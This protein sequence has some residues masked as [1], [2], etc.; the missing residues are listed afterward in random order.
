MDADH[1]DKGVTFAGRNTVLKNAAEAKVPLEWVR[2]FA[3][4][5]AKQPEELFKPYGDQYGVQKVRQPITVDFVVSPTRRWWGG[6]GRTRSVGVLKD[7]PSRGIRVR[8]RNIQIDNTQ[9]MRDIFAVSHRGGKPRTSYARFSDYYVG[10]IF[11]DPRAA[12]PNARRDGFEENPGWQT[13]RDEL[14]EIVAESYGK[15]AYKTSTADQLSP[16]S[17]SKRLANFE[18]SAKPLIE[19]RQADWD[20]VSQAIAEANGLQ[21]KLYSA[22]KVA[23]DQELRQ[24]KD[25]AATV[26]AM[27]RG[28]DG[29]VLDAPMSLDCG[30]QVDEALSVLVQKLY[31]AMK[32]RLSPLEWQRARDVV[33]EVSGEAP[34]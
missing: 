34:D 22:I 8:V 15:L 27:K 24:I 10:E 3:T 21:K 9:V 4:D 25:I 7:V 12:I 16:E 20:L 18:K 13:I 29:L 33:K 30:Q 31:R 17:L 2:V 1:P 11:V 32:Q 6:V 19:D 14:D 23:D 5:G 26:S 28:L